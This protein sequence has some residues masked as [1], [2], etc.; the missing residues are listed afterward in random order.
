MAKKS[1]ETNSPEWQLHENMKSNRLLVGSYIKDAERSTQ[2]AEAARKKY[3]L[4]KEALL[5]L[6]PDFNEDD[7]C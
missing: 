7:Y 6:D 4:Y 1:F 3:E 2:M 5:K